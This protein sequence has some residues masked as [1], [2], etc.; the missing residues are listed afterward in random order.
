[1]DDGLVGH[2]QHL[3]RWSIGRD[4][5]EGHQTVQLAAPQ[6]AHPQQMQRHSGRG[7]GDFGDSEDRTDEEQGLRESVRLERLA[8]AAYIECFGKGGMR[9]DAMTTG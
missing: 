7:T 6:V 5:R 4:H 2:R 3:Q 8:E 9:A 1:M